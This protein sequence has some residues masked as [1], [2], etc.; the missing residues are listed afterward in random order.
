M[1]TATLEI[2]IGS[3]GC[4]HVLSCYAL[5]FTA[6][7]EK[8]D[9]FFAILQDVLSAIPLDESHVVLGDFNAHMGARGMDDEWWYERGSHGYGELN[10]TGRELLSFLSINEATVYNTLFQK[11]DIHKQTWQ[12]PKSK[13]LHC[14]D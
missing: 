13:Q 14:I 11:K 12:H 2:G 5:T 10:D 3:S 4:L 9:A 6:S 8:K 7:R 1:V